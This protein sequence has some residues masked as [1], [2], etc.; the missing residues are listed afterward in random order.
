MNRILPFLSAGPCS[1]CRRRREVEQQLETLKAE[2]E[3]IE[4]LCPDVFEFYIPSARCIIEPPDDDPEEGRIRLVVNTDSESAAIDSNLAKF[5][6]AE[7]RRRA[8]DL[9]SA[10]AA[11]EGATDVSAAGPGGGA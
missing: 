7:L 3:R 11:I 6:V 8:G 1:R 5:A 2:A 9:E 10:A 4:A